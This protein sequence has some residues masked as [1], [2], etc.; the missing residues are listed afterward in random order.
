MGVHVAVGGWSTRPQKG[1]KYQISDLCCIWKVLTT[2]L[3]KNL[4][5]RVW[6]KRVERG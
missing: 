2:V 3:H 1:W 5:F 6:G 4:N